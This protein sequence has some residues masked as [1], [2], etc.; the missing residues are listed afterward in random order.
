MDRRDFLK[1]G[2]ALSTI[3]Y[4]PFSRADSAVI[5]QQGFATFK[6]AWVKNPKLV[7]QNCANWC[8]AASIA[9]VFASNGHRVAQERIV[10][11]TFGALECRPSGYPKTITEALSREW[12]DD[13][14]DDFESVV[15]AGYD[16]F[17]GVVAIDNGFIIE[18]L[19]DDKPILY[20]NT[21]HAM[22]NVLVEYAEYPNGAVQV[23]A[24][25]V[26]DPWPASA[27][28]RRIGGPEIAPAHLGG[29]MTYLA[30]VEIN[31]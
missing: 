9:M 3:G 5:G 17:S 23:G 4:G 31:D 20:C 16:Y 8:W 1:M 13:S 30:A 21:H 12:T 29:Q 15:T 22:L 7:T 6:R 28:F 10:K 18:Q 24:A 27:G 25:G 14:G 19:S 2:A 11:E 26:L